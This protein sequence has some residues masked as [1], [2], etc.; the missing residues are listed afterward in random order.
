MDTLPTTSYISRVVALPPGLARQVFDACRAD[1]QH[2][3]L[4][5]HRWTVPAGSTVFLSLDGDGCTVAPDPTRSWAMRA[6][7]GTLHAARVG[8]TFAVEVELNPWSA[9][10]TEVGIRLVGRRRASARYVHA[11]GAVIDAVASE[12][13]LRGL[14]ALH[15]SHTTGT[16][17][18]RQEVTAS[19]WL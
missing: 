12:L 10:R 5:P 7:P 13:E 15:P 19:A 17:G 3:S 8:G 4:V 14:L 11:A 6:V 1:R 16:T 2:R 9:S 18:S